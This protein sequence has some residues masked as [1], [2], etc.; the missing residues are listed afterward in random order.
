M[1]ELG[2]WQGMDRYALMVLALQTGAG[3]VR[4]G[5]IGDGGTDG[6]RGG[7]ALSPCGLLHARACNVYMYMDTCVMCW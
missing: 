2:P 1:R 3:P 6:V 4:R 7:L 5:Q